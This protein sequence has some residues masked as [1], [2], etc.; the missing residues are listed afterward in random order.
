M[1]P[2]A[3]GYCSGGTGDKVREAK[4]RLTG[5][6]A[7]GWNSDNKVT[8]DVARARYQIAYL[9]ATRDVKS[10]ELSELAH[11]CYMCNNALP[12][13][14]W[15]DLGGPVALSTR[16]LQSQK[17]KMHEMQDLA[18]Q[19]TRT[20]NLKKELERR[21]KTYGT[22]EESL[23]SVTMLPGM[24]YRYNI[25]ATEG[26]SFVINEKGCSRKPSSALVRPKFPNIVDTE[27]L[28]PI[29][30]PV[31]APATPMLAPV[32]TQG[33]R[34]R[35][36]ICFPNMNSRKAQEQKR[37]EAKP[38]P[39]PKLEA[40]VFGIWNTSRDAWQC[41]H[42]NKTPASIN[43][44]GNIPPMFRYGIQYKP[45]GPSESTPGS[46]MVLFTGLKLSTTWSDVLSRVRGG[47]ILRVH[48]GGSTTMMVC[49][50]HP[51]AAHAYARRVKTLN[52]HGRNVKVTLVPTAS[53]PVRT[54]L[55]DDIGL[56]GITRCL[57][58]PE[59]DDY[60]A[61]ALEVC[62]VKRRMHDFVASTGPATPTPTPM[63]MVTTATA[64]ND[65]ANDT[66]PAVDANIITDT[67]AKATT[68]TV[69][70]LQQSTGVKEKEETRE[71]YEEW[72]V[73]NGSEPQQQD[74]N[75]IQK[76]YD[77]DD[78]EKKE[79]SAPGVLEKK[80][81]MDEEKE[82]DKGKEK[83]KERRT[84]ILSFRS[85]EQ[86]QNA[87]RIIVRELPHRGV[88]YAPDPCAGPLEELKN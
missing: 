69:K 4:R 1:D 6:L 38:V 7:V 47:A 20:D 76:I 39:H 35:P 81:D 87:Y 27:V 10:A 86:A 23:K 29:S 50:V 17:E 42:Q 80:E 22:I 13:G 24:D 85:V 78:A 12:K 3:K 72:I 67:T 70:D 84:L 56:R 57:A 61:R 68:T 53:Y 65:T 75:E 5:L 52:L 18:Q 73:L 8:E 25:T 21:L 48:R 26:F 44:D 36:V 82:K 31:L 46:R 33:F 51:P 83:E 66:T 62:L 45:D 19:I 49:F 77:D 16:I 71:L 59:C 74:N 79:E 55:M 54:A 15:T 37:E 88:Y 14:D 43:R 11:F 60:L 63:S 32:N 2:F 41:L 64:A 34:P 28:P 40:P 58:L 9:E 30:T